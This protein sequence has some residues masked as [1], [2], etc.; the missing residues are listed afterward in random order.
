MEGGLWITLQLKSQGSV[1]LLQNYVQVHEDFFVLCSKKIYFL[2][3][4]LC[5]ASK[6]C[7]NTYY[8]VG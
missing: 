7:F 4:S 3:A 1:K 5:V 8:F 6:L 2:L